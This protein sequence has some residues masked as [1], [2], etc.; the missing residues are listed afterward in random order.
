M[1]VG[2]DLLGKFSYLQYIVFAK[3]LIMKTK[4]LL[5]DATVLPVNGI[6]TISWWLTRLLLMDQRIL[7]EQSSSLYDLLKVF[8][9]E[10]LQN[11]GTLV[12]VST[13]WGNQLHDIDPSEIVSTFHLE[14][15]L[16][17]HIYRRV[18][19]CRKHFESAEVAAGLQLSVTGVLGFRTVRQVEPKAKMV[20]V[21]NTSSTNTSDVCP[22]INQVIHTHDSTIGDASDVFVTPKLLGNS[23]ESESGVQ[24]IHA[25]GSAAHLKAI[26]QAVI[27][28]RCVLIE[29]SSR[30]DEMQRWDMAPY[31]E[32]IDSQQSS[33]FI[34]KFFCDLLRIRWESTRSRTKGRALEM[35]DKLVEG[36]SNS[37]P[38]VT[39]RIP[40]C[41]VIYVPTI[42][43]LRKEFAELLVSCGLI[44]EAIKIFEDLELCDNLIYCNWYGVID[45]HYPNLSLSLSL[46]RVANGSWFCV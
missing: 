29:K 35:M 44:G 2:S 3:M 31:I 40:F 13:Y 32:A 10:T 5:S 43:A 6:G 27:L 16:L 25:G 26:Q 14:A 21:A 7:D 33:C 17:E 42:P 15:G 30:E 46:S 8:M 22:S 39:Q 11:F 28:S 19:S 38:G 20:L 1:S 41:Y 45:N 34:L 9:A 4:D 23:H 24:C 18:D 37:S 12:N 36:I